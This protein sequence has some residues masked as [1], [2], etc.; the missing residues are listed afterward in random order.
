ME[1]IRR[2][3]IRRVYYSKN[4]ENGNSFNIGCERVR[5]MTS[6]MST[7]GHKLFQEK[8]QRQSLQGKLQ[9]IEKESGGKIQRIDKEINQGNRSKGRR[10]MK[11]R[12]R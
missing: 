9:G 1:F 8:V 2:F 10:R 7:Q 4:P 6:T 12:K 5:E 11:G 3:G